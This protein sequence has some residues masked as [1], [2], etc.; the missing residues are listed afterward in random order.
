MWLEA[1]G[2]NMVRLSK[3]YTKTGDKGKTSLGNSKRVSKAHLRIEAIGLV[4]E[5]NAA[6][7]WAITV[8]TSDINLVLKRIQNDLFDMG[9]DLCMPEGNGLKITDEQVVFLEDTL[10]SYNAHLKPLSSFILPG[11]SKEAAPLHMARTI[12]RRAERGL[13]RLDEK[14]SINPFIIKYI[15]R[16]SDLLFVFSRFVNNKGEDDI[17]WIPGKNCS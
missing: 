9:A 3:I 7:G 10:D 15:N 11:G 5:V 4:D 16:L 17:L 6:I 12:A 14:T 2:S 1:L 13:V 8:V